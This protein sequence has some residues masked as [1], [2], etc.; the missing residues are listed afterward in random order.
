MLYVHKP[1]KQLYLFLI[2]LYNS[3]CFSLHL[4]FLTRATLLLTLFSIGLPEQEKISQLRGFCG[5]VARYAEKDEGFGFQN[6]AR[7]HTSD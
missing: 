4:A 6:S 2:V 1:R 3:R 7:L 5:Q